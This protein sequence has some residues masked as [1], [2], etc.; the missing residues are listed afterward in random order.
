MNKRLGELLERVASWPP[1]AQEDAIAI[2]SNS[3]KA[4]ANANAGLSPA[5]QEAK[6]ASLREIL[7]RSIE[8]GGSY[9]DEEVEASISAALDARE[10]GRKSA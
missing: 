3:L 4:M 5:E 2:T 8:R 9:T 6:L 7:R 10:R 1:D